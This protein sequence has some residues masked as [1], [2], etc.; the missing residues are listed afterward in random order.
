MFWKSF[1]EDNIQPEI[2]VPHPLGANGEN[3]VTFWDQVNYNVEFS[4]DK[5]V[6]IF[7]IIRN[8]SR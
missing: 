1:Y 4:A 2:Q 7:G 8:A 5:I 3:T 6:H